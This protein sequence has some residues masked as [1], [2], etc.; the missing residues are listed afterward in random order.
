MS[1]RSAVWD[2]FGIGVCSIMGL[3]VALNLLAL[4]IPGFLS[5]SMTP[6]LIGTFVG[7]FVLLLTLGGTRSVVEVTEAGIRGV[8]WGRKVI[9]W[10]AISAASVTGN[11]L[12]VVPN[13]TLA[14]VQP[15]YM[16]YRYLRRR[17]KSA[18]VAPLDPATAGAISGVLANKRLPPLP[19]PQ[20]Q[21]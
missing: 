12:Q 3:G 5:P 15:P 18:L 2:P 21:R 11:L 6:S 20:T 9:P 16:Y 4:L 7:S 17:A 14:F 1:V 13:D 8:A 10:D 19:D